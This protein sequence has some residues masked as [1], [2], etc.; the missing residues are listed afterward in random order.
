MIYRTIH[1]DFANLLFFSDF[2]VFLD[3]SHFIVNKIVAIVIELLLARLL[4]HR[5]LGS[6][7]QLYVLGKGRSSYRCYSLVPLFVL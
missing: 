6:W 7:I 2:D 5:K 1:F 4:L 3:F